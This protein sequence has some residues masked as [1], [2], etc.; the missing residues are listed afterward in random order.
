MNAQLNSTTFQQFVASNKG[1][2]ITFKYSDFKYNNLEISK[3]VV[4][5]CGDYFTCKNQES[6]AKIDSFYYFSDCQLVNDPLVDVLQKYKVVVIK[7]FPGDYIF[8]Y[9]H[10]TNNP[11]IGYG[12]IIHGVNLSTNKPV[13]F[14]KSI[15]KVWAI[16]DGK[17]TQVWDKEEQPIVPKE[18]PIVPKEQSVV[19]KEQSVVP[20]EQ[21]DEKVEEEKKKGIYIEYRGNPRIVDIINEYTHANGKEYVLVK[22]L[23]DHDKTKT[24]FKEYIKFM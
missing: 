21:L 1:K 20:K 3:V 19:P 22:D 11:V 13:S 23:S 10:A 16:I 2:K 24:L 6:D 15:K 7:S 9:S 8:R 12:K 18:Q 5:V 4:D 14:S 17:Y